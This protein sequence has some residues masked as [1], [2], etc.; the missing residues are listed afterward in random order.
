MPWTLLNSGTYGFADGNTGHNCAYPGGQPNTGDLLILA[1]ASDTTVTTPTG[2]T[3]AVSDVV[4]QGDYL[5]YRKA[6]GS[7]PTSI[8]VTT[9][10]DFPTVVAFLR[11]SGADTV[12]LDVTAAT[13]TNNA[14]AFTTPAISP[15][16][17]AGTGELAVIVACCQEPSAG[18]GTG[19]TASAGYTIRA[20]TGLTGS[21][22]LG[23][24]AFVAARTDAT[25]SETPSITWATSQYRNRT[26][27]FA[28]FTPAATVDATVT[29]P[30]AA[31]A[32]AAAN[33]P[34][35]TA[36]AAVTVPDAA[37]ATAQAL[38]P[39]VPLATVRAG[40]LSASTAPQARLSGATT[41]AGPRHVL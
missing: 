2:Y 16:A 36:D 9:T 40:S 35:V 13:R 12:P 28:A 31:A 15:S 19:P 25:G 5:Y 39:D 10:G 18:A 33:A 21:G 17:L 24:Q 14:D 23:V 20:D 4:N 37:T 3:L 38:A 27:L 8:T 29:V 22:A 6:G 30:T 11:Y 7:E 41:A 1:V 34:A 32:T 26:A